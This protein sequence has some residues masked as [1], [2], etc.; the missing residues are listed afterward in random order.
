M[1]IKITDIKLPKYSYTLFQCNINA[2]YMN[3]I[4]VQIL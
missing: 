4:C 3:Y 2:N 1:D